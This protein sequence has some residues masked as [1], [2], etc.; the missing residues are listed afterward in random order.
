MHL[1][2]IAPWTQRR[3]GTVALRGFLETLFALQKRTSTVGALPK[4]PQRL[5]D[6]WKK[7]ECAVKAS[8]SW[9]RNT[10]SQ[11]GKMGFQV[12]SSLPAPDSSESTKWVNMVK[13][14]KGPD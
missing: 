3:K 7:G 14:K 13:K 5:D 6:G 1:D 9:K 4:W 8:F 12:V 11:S 2:L 10:L